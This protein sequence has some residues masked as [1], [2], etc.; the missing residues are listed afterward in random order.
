MF[1]AAKLRSLAFILININIVMHKTKP[2]FELKTLED[3]SDNALLDE[4]RRVADELNGK[5]LTIENFNQLAR[6]H[7]TTLRYR[8]GSW[9]NALNLAGISEVIA[10][11]FNPLTRETVILSLRD[12]AKEY[13]GTSVT[14]DEIARKLGVHRGTLTRRFG[15]WEDLLNEVGL[16]PVPLGRRYMD[17]E[18]Y[19]NIIVLWTHYGRQPH[20][21]ELKKPPSTVGPKAYIG[22]WG[23]WRAALGAFVKYVNQAPDVAQTPVIEKHSFESST[24]KS[25][26]IITPRS[27]SL[28]LRYKVLSRDRFRC[29]ICGRSPAKDLSIELHVDHIVPWSKDGQNTEENLRTLCFDCNLGK[30]ANIENK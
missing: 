1:Y 26:S 20:F 10:P 2:M 11:R 29:V 13:P 22:R 19:E 18:C 9:K 24:T 27:I 23:G 14:Q 15:K 30:G 3:Y 21:A 28:T 16:S 5:H 6:V 25:T 8:F 17:E 4:L 12:Y 7:S